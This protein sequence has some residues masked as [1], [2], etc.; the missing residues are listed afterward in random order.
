M[1]E[2]AVDDKGGQQQ[3]L[4]AQNL[5]I[6][7]H[8]I[9]LMLYVHI[10]YKVNNVYAFSFYNNYDFCH[11]TIEVFKK[12]PLSISMDLVLCFSVPSAWAVLF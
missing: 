5:Y 7:F 8:A 10:S 9:V 4:L 3:N 12:T 2:N 11:S 6:S 1:V